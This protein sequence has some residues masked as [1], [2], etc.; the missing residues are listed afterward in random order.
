MPWEAV[1]PPANVGAPPWVKSTTAASLGDI[2]AAMR[3]PAAPRARVSE[4]AVSEGVE[5]V[6]TG[7]VVGCGVAL[8]RAGGLTGAVSRSVTGGATVGG[9]GAGGGRRG[10]S[11]STQE[12]S[13]ACAE[14]E[15][16]GGCVRDDQDELT[17]PRLRCALAMS[18]SAGTQS[19]LIVLRGV[20]MQ[21]PM[22]SFRDDAYAA[23]IG[24]RTSGC[25]ASRWLE[26]LTA[27]AA[28]EGATM[29]A[30]SRRRCG[31]FLHHEACP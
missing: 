27:V 5:G 9:A 30:V 22:R 10:A 19:R 23:V 4:A 14:G 6:A 3:L 24:P 8:R 21:L 31:S 11:S 1:T 28:K 12:T 18:M 2:E 25:V 17:M 26:R 20:G 15:G 16:G 13:K 7:E 29:E